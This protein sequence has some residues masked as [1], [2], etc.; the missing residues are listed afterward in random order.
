MHKKRQKTPK[1]IIVKCV[2]LDVLNC[3]NIKD[4]LLP[5]NTNQQKINKKKRQKTP[6]HYTCEL[7]ESL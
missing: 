2:T 6:D 5:I 1:N 4:I 3:Q 7:W